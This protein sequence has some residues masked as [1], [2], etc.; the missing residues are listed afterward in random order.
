MILPRSLYDDSPPARRTRVQDNP[1]LLYSWWATVFSL[2]IILF[3]LSGRY[4]RNERL[5]PEDKIM[6]MSMIPLMARIALVHVVLIWG[7]NNVNVQGLIDPNEIHHREIG[8]KVVLAARISYTL[9]IWMAKFTVSEFL[10][11]LTERFWKKGYE[12]VLHGIRVFLAVTFVAVLVA[13]LSE[14]Q[15]FPHY[16]QVVPDPGPKCRQGY[17][18]LISMGTTDIVT[19][20][21]LVAFPIPI[22]CQSSMPLKRKL[23]LLSLFSMSLILI[24][25]TGA[26]IALVIERHGLQQYRTVLAST[27]ILFAA[28][29]SNAI[30]LGSFLRDR[31]LKKQR[32]KSGSA[33]DSMD[34]SMSRRPTLQ[35]RSSDENLAREL[36]FRTKPELTERPNSITRP[37]PVANL[38]LLS[39]PLLS[40]NWKFP[41]SGSAAGVDEISR[42]PDEPL[43][44]PRSGRRV[45]FCDVGGLLET[46]SRN[47]T[48]PSPTDTVVAHDFA[49]QP[50]R[51]SRASNIATPNGRTYPP[52]A[53]RASR[54]SQ[55][56]EDIELIN[57]TGQ[58][59]QDP[60][61][62]LSESR[63]IAVLE[64]SGSSTLQA[65]SSNSTPNNAS[66][67]EHSPP[68][69]VARSTTQWSQ[70][71]GPALQDAGGLLSPSRKQS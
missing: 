14:C 21:L 35:T 66:T 11:R 28:I 46:G 27:E 26:R 18:H 16:W 43:P 63:E 67:H 25:I 55:Q 51:G 17:S 70:S 65:S 33:T 8:S 60:G 38:A 22:I 24:G 4:I 13:T 53:R 10:K 34:R 54:L 61:G 15:P 42:A 6:A 48:A 19:D 41:S 30:V 29:I 12:I 7:T 58:Q 1:T 20:I 5:F 64:S 62:L 32:Y 9:F 37:A 59:L 52:P 39:P 31:G 45:S 50:R 49:P 23:S 57:R 47:S 69:P 56:S 40:S 3:R 44:S 2:V 71:S 36:G 68:P